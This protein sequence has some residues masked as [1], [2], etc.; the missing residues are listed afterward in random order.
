LESHLLGTFEDKEEEQYV[1][2][3]MNKTL[4][5]SRF[6]AISRHGGASKS[7][8]KGPPSLATFYMKKHSR[9]PTYSTCDEFLLLILSTL[10]HR[11]YEDMQV[12]VVDEEMKSLVALII[13]QQFEFLVPRDDL[14]AIFSACPRYLSKDRDLKVHGR[15]PFS[16]WDF[17]RP[18]GKTLNDRLFQELVTDFQLW[19]GNLSKLTSVTPTASAKVFSSSLSVRMTR[20]PKSSARDESDVTGVVSFRQF[21]EFLE[22]TVFPT[23]LRSLAS[24]ISSIQQQPA[25][26]SQQ[27]NDRESD[28]HYEEEYPDNESFALDLLSLDEEPVRHEVD[29]IDLTS[30]SSKYVHGDFD[31]DIVRI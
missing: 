23:M 3:L 21:K 29:G 4:R 25:M 17:F 27:G 18:M 9:H 31:I 5:E 24:Q 30:T 20:Q 12:P 11:Q 26:A 14:V 13:L 28:F 6:F 19:L 8:A 22:Q 7:L 16:V 2:L 15:I 10:L 1:H